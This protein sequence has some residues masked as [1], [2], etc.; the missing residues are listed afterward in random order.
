V[1]NNLIRKVRSVYSYLTNR[2]GSAP[3]RR[4][5]AGMQIVP[6]RK[7]TPRQKRYFGFG[8]RQFSKVMRRPVLRSALNRIL[9]LSAASCQFAKYSQNA[10]I[11]TL[12]GKLSAYQL[13]AN[14]LANLRRLCSYRVPL[15]AAGFVVAKN[16]W[17]IRNPTTTP[18]AARL[19]R[20]NAFFGHL[21][22]TTSTMKRLLGNVRFYVLVKFY[23]LST[24]S[25]GFFSG[26]TGGNRAWNFIQLVE[27][28]TPI[29]L[30]KLGYATNQSFQG[31]FQKQVTVNG[32]LP[33]RQ[34]QV[35]HPADVLLLKTAELTSSDI[36]LFSKLNRA[37]SP[38]LIKKI[39]SASA[40]RISS[41]NNTRK[42]GK[43]KR[44]NNKTKL[45]NR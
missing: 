4:R 36:L 29:I 43:P 33:S 12:S 35:A 5:A 26:G 22:R 39:Y 37:P 40:L 9:N 41:W 44:L 11:K 17:F 34:Q 14:K 13:G 7:L 10:Q 31:V 45:L 30:V 27:A 8:K 23:G 6:F 3:G 2:K 24:K 25:V 16:F 15:D 42:L 38:M 18:G 28:L 20:R 19:R 1:K 21:L 32:Q